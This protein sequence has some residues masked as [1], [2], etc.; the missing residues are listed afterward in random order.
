MYSQRQDA[1]SIISQIQDLQ[2][3]LRSWRLRELGVVIPLEAS[4]TNAPEGLWQ[5]GSLEM[6]SEKA[7]VASGSPVSTGDPRKKD[8]CSQDDVSQDSRR[9]RRNK[10]DDMGEGDWSAKIDWSRRSGS[11]RNAQVE[12]GSAARQ[13]GERAH[14]RDLGNAASWEAPCRVETAASS[15]N[16]ASDLKSQLPFETSQNKIAVCLQDESGAGAS[17]ESPWC[18]RRSMCPVILS[19]ARYSR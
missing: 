15:H 2:I 6:S 14:S 17:L 12:S 9:K 19:C 3:E 18:K 11:A 1:Q 10:R 7:A 13:T 8:R 16:G 5:Q 4:G